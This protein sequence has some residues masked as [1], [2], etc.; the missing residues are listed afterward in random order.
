MN[1]DGK[2]WK[3]VNNFPILVN[4]RY[5]LKEL[6]TRGAIHYRHL[7]LGNGYY[8]YLIVKYVKHNLTNYDKVM[9]DFLS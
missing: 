5:S 8:D 6:R 9:D 2:I 7:G 1:K 4:R 3:V